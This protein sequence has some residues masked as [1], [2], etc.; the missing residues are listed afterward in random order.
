MMSDEKEIRDLVRTWMVATKSGD[1]A[2]VLSLMTD[3]VMFLVPGQ[4]P[5]GKSV[6]EKASE[7]QA[8]SLVEFDGHSEILEIRVLGDW[9]YMLTKLKVVATIPSKEQPIV[10]AGH[11]LTILRKDSGKWK[12]ARD[13]NLLAPA[14]ESGDGA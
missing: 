8:D 11:T 9:A 10:R 12:I 13:A 2:T 6:F 1:S 7:A 4:E 14:N 3:D 5:F